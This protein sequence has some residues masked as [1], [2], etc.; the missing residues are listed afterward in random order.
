MQPPRRR[1]KEP[2]GFGDDGAVAAA[3]HFVERPDREAAARQPGVEAKRGGPA[4]TR[5]RNQTVM[6]GRL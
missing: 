2:R 1:H 6:S 3:R 4:W 5:T